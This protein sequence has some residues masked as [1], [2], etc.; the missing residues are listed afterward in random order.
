MGITVHA[1]PWILLSLIILAEFTDVLDGYVAR[2]LNQVTDLGKIL[3]P[4]AD[5]IYRISIFLS[6]TLPPVSIPIWVIFIL[7]Y[8]DLAISTL[9]TICAFKGLILA[10]RMSGKIKAVVQGVSVVC[11]LIFMIYESM[12]TLT[13]SDVS[14]YSSIVAIVAALYTLYSG[15]D[16]IYANRTYIHKVLGTT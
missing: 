5:S 16:Y 3:D 7:L 2:K 12:G 1:L 8:R 10:A 6:F 11:I 4:M 9:R 13:M 14:F 15:V